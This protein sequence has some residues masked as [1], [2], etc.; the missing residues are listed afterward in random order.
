MYTINQSTHTV[1]FDDKLTHVNVAAL[2]KNREQF[3]QELKNLKGDTIYLDFSKCS[4][5]DTSGFAY[6][7]AV[8]RLIEESKDFTNTQVKLESAQRIK[9]YATLYDLNDF[10]TKFF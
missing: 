5:L 8:L 3:I 6:L 4:S 2:D 7:L 10:F 9:V 1:F